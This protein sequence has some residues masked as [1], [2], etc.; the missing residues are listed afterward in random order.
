MSPPKLTSYGL[1]P[2]RLD[3]SARSAEAA[4]S[5][6]ARGGAEG[7]LVAVFVRFS[8]TPGLFDMTPTRADGEPPTADWRRS[9][10]AVWTTEVA[11]DKNA[12]ISIARPP[13]L[14]GQGVADGQGAN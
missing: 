6:R 13:T 4:P 3:W 14:G 2:L 8:G 10:T 12:P 1:D 11:S 7:W 9:T 5:R